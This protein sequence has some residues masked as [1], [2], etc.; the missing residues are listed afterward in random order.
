MKNED[1]NWL[2][3]RWN[4]LRYYPESEFFDS[5]EEARSAIREYGSTWRLCLVT[6]FCTVPAVVVGNFCETR[7]GKWAFFPTY[8]IA[9]LFVAGFTFSIQIGIVKRKL[10]T[11]LVK[12]GVPICIPCGYDL[13]GLTEPRCPECGT[14]FD[15]ALLGEKVDDASES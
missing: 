9:L 14:S 2:W 5:D 11:E 12:R 6:L 8:A 7:I 15:S 10:R 3:K 1:R 13:R 4:G